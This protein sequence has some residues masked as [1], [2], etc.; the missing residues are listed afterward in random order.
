M[1]I[2]KCLTCSQ[3]KNQST[4]LRVYGKLITDSAQ[5]LEAWSKHFK[6]LSQSRVLSNDGLGDLEQH[7]TELRFTSFHREKSFLDIP[8][9]EKEVQQ[10]VDRKMKLRKASRLD[11]LTAEH[12][13]YGGH[14]IIVW[15]TEIFNAIIEFEIIP[16]S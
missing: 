13:Q 1:R 10:I 11:G 14:T 16:S 3:R 5:L 9:T 12:I 2:R 15:L 8:T 7:V 6:S 4:C